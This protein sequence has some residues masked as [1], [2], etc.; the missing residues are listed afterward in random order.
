[1]AESQTAFD[2]EAYKYEQ[3]TGMA[4]VMPDRWVGHGRI[5]IHD[6]DLSDEKR[7]FAQKLLVRLN[8]KYP[9]VDS[10]RLAEKALEA[11]ENK[12]G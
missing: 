8:Q 4:G 5:L 1:M 6:R 12:L 10:E 7:A 9:D 2:M 3:D 11:T